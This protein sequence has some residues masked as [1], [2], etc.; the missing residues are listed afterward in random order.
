[1]RRSILVCICVTVQKPVF[2]EGFVKQNPEFCKQKFL[3]KG[4]SHGFLLASVRGLNRYVF[5]IYNQ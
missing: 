1:M 2:R 4:G 5:V 3:T